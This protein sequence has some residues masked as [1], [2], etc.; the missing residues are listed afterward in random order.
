MQ[1]LLVIPTAQ[2]HIGW[3]AA[4]LA[5]V[6][7]APPASPLPESLRASLAARLPCASV[8]VCVFV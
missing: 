1:Q 8:C 7:A 6:S 4:S 2:K 3:P 5:E